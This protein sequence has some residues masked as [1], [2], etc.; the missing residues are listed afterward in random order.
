MKITLFIAFAILLTSCSQSK[1]TLDNKLDNLKQYRE[2]KKTHE[3]I[4]IK[5]KEII[6]SIDQKIIPIKCSIYSDVGAKEQWELECQDFYDEQQ[7]KI[8]TGSITE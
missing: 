5:E 1:P 3:N 2:S 4:I 6:D 7:S 8:D